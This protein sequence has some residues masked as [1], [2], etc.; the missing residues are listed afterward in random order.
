[1]KEH[2]MSLFDKVKS[3]FGKSKDT[4]SPVRRAKGDEN[5]DAA[6]KV[7]PGEDSPAE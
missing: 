5:P 7:V 6:E 2:T 3:R 1:M 4:P